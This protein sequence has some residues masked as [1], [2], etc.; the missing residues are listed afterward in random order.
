MKMKTNDRIARIAMWPPVMLAA[1]RIV[2]AN[3]RTNM[4]MI[5][6]G[7]SRIVHGQRQAVRHQVLPV[8][9]EAV[10][11]RAGDD[12]REERDGRQR[13]GDVEVARRGDAAVQQPREERVLGHAWIT[14]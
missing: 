7:I 14:V 2:S 10:R 13:R 8:L 11:A 6:I 5:S 9:D 1:S 12:D 4:P 3:G